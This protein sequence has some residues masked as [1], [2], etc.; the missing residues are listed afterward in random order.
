MQAPNREVKR[1][2]LLVS[3]VETAVQTYAGANPTS[4]ALFERAHL[5]MPGGNTRSA[6]HFDPFPLYVE[7]SSGCHLTDRDGHDYLDVLGEFTA[8]LFGHQDPVITQAIAETTRQGMVNGA[9]GE[10][11][12]KLAEWVCARF[13]GIEKVRFCNSGTEANLFALAL[14]KA[15]TGRS[16]F[17][18]FAGAYHGGVFNFGTAGGAM[19][20]PYDFVKCPYNDIEACVSAIRRVGADLAAVIVEPMMSN[21]GC[22]PAAPEFLA[23]LRRECSAVGALLIFDEIVTARMGDGGMQGIVAVTPDLTTLGK[24]LGGGFS[25]GAFGGRAD[26]LDL[27]DPARPDALIHAGTFNNNPYTMAV[28]YAALSSLF[29]PARA[30]KLFDDG[31]ALR[32]RLNA[33]AAEIS[34]AIQ[35]TGVGSIMN[36]HF[37]KGPIRRPGDL[38]GEPRSLF[39]LFHFDLLARGLYAAARGQINLSLPM[40]V[41]EFDLITEAVADFFRGRRALLQV[42]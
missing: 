37:V 16:K 24:F 8:G 33:M 5:S 17:I 15:A 19:N 40:G 23:A 20:A 3:A 31:E 34:P 12:I 41:R 36:I 22:L 28:G 6:L 13:A 7:N 9:P 35:F 11:E 29:T 18:C 4:R 25:A 1:N 32:A 2:D 10:S 39:R 26:L 30:R 38:A 14:A 42:L 21:G 27:M